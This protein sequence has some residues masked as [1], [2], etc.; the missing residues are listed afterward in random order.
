MTKEQFTEQLTERM[1]ELL[2]SEG[3]EVSHDVFMKNNDV[4]RYGIVIQKQG[5]LISPTIYIENY[6]DDYIHMKLTMDEITNQLLS[7]LHNI[8]EHAEQYDSL[9]MDFESCQDKI[10]YRLISTKKNQKILR[11]IPH[12]PFLNM[13]ITFA[14]V[15]NL[16]SDGLESLRISNELLEKWDVSVKQLYQLAKENT[17]R[18]FPVRIDSLEKIIFSYLGMEREALPIS[19]D[20]LG[21]KE[22]PLLLIT[23]ESGINGASVLLY[24]DLIQELA[25][26]YKSNLYILPSSV[27][28]IIVIPGDDIKMLP[29]L[30]T[31]VADINK[32]HV[33]REEV[34]ADTAF[35]YDWKEKKF[36][37]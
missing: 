35:Y 25:E 20:Q 24:E 10:I 17:P 7:I 33:S 18:I 26:K 6:Y 31:M 14:V 30:A 3:Y 29:G 34:L 22:T 37:Y 13:S 11:G 19:E 8:R 16:S 12:I 28:E 23:N 2:S 32:K 4:S 1:Q 36:I 9:A 27:H 15:C 21:K 5:E